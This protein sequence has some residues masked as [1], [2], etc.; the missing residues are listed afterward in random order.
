MA[1]TFAGILALIGMQVVFLRAIKNGAGVDGTVLQAL[2][3]MALL[4]AVGF[5]V[6]SI[7]QMTVDDAVRTRIQAELDKL[8]QT[9][10]APTGS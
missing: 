9:E 3:A 8:S 5:V 6:G 7:A 2:A 1:R 4:A 10:Q